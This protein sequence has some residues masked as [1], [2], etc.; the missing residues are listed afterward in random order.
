MQV[1]EQDFSAMF[2][3]ALSL[4][5]DLRRCTLHTLTSGAFYL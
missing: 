3:Q 5:S 2:H 4:T 1:A